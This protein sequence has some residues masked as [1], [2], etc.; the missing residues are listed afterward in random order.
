MKKSLRI[1]ISLPLV[2]ALLG[3]GAA[4]ARADGLVLPPNANG[5]DNSG[6]QIEACPNHM[7]LVL[8]ST[9]TPE[10]DDAPRAGLY[11]D[12]RWTIEIDGY[13]TFNTD[14]NQSGDGHLGSSISQNWLIPITNGENGP[15]PGDVLDLTL[16]AKAYV[17]AFA[18]ETLDA[19]PF[20]IQVT[21][22]DPE[23]FANGSGTRA[24]PFIITT[25]EELNL[26]RCHQNKHF[27]LG[28]S[29]D[30]NDVPWVPIMGGYYDW[31]MNNSYISLS[32]NGN[33]HSIS[34]LY[35]SPQMLEVGLLGNV[36]DSLIKN[37]VI[38]S[39]EVHGFDSV[40]SVVGNARHS[41]FVDVNIT[42]ANINAYR[43]RAGSLVGHI[44]YRNLL[45][46][47]QS[48]GVVNASAYMYEYEAWFEGNW[49]YTGDGLYEIG[50][51]IGY[52]NGDGT[53]YENIRS[54]VDVTISS[55]F[56][57]A[58]NTGYAGRALWVG[59]LVGEVGQTVFMTNVQSTSTV[60]LDIDDAYYVGGLV[61]KSEDALFTN[62]EVDSTI[63]AI[64]EYATSVGGV[65]GESNHA[66]IN[67][68]KSTTEI[69]LYSGD[70][71]RA[72]AGAV[73]NFEY[74][75]ITKSEFNSEINLVSTDENGSESN[76]AEDVAGIIGYIDSGIVQ[77][78][79]SISA[80][81]IALADGTNNP[82]NVNLQG[83]TNR[84]VT[85][86]GGIIGE[87][88]DYSSYADIE[89]NSA[90]SV[91]EFAAINGVSGGIAYQSDGN[92]LNLN[93]LVVRGSINLPENA[94]YVGGLVGEFGGPINAVNALVSVNISEVANMENV[95]PL[96]GGYS[97]S[98][99]YQTARTEVMSS[100]NTFWDSTVETMANNYETFGAGTATADMSNLEWLT[101]NNFDTTRI[102][103]VSGTFPTLRLVLGTTVRSFVK[104]GQAN[105]KLSLVFSPVKKGKRTFK[106]NLVST[107]AN[108]K[109]R[110]VI[111]RGG[112]KVKTIK[113]GTLDILG[114]RKFK[115]KVKLKK[116]D[117]LRV[118]I[119]KKVVAR[120]LV[121]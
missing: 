107:L 4:P 91:G 63:D 84:R 49:N 106:I 121:R 73:G 39:P 70:R 112:V 29:I 83:Q 2:A 98:E 52:D 14:P 82:A 18:S 32:L 110:L 6:I 68:L 61:G 53:S 92:A 35:V 5:V 62:V 81:D 10:A 108:K 76:F 60:T 97:G 78:V 100:P 59:G 41:Q 115:S 80:I 64:V 89:S 17:D 90:I 44:D 50:G 58:P 75:A 46:N 8:P 74:G 23:G 87:H 105:K 43:S 77:N 88:D 45:R 40:G 117:K 55:E 33:G 71:V 118:K 13:N 30:L 103:K 93:H 85:S 104:Y 102:W 3:L 31:N 20:T 27:V 51:L 38:E 65:A 111:I 109:V 99:E 69:N 47:I 72:I 37:L 11:H 120:H 66:S 54:N 22:L 16:T 1:A 67:E 113:L 34:N 36:Y 42:D 94:E 48:E 86:I 116:A 25:R 96:L 79:R 7:Q 28:N 56:Y 21:V 15:N 119:G 12:F 19:A 101:A 95:G 114:D 9:P 24:D 57:Q 26:V